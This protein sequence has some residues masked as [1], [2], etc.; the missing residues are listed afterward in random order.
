MLKI[1]SMFTPNPRIRCLR[2]EM[3]NRS[4]DTGGNIQIGIQL[5]KAE[6]YAKHNETIQTIFLSE[7]RN[8]FRMLTLINLSI[9]D[10][11]GD[12]VGFLGFDVINDDI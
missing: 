12:R 2:R 3:I 7:D 10:V 1:V 8:M 6:I 4:E 5:L 11:P 9:H